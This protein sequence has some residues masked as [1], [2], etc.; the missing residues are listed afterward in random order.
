[1]NTPN[2][3]IEGVMPK[4]NVYLSDEL[5]AAVRD[6]GFPVS[7]VCQQALAEAVR[8]VG[9]AR[10]ASAAMRDP[11]FDPE[12]F[13]KLGAGVRERMTPRLRRA[14][15]LARPASESSGR[16]ESTDLLRGV[17]DE[18]ENL[19]VGLLPALDVDT[20]ELREATR[21]REVTEPGAP[22]APAQADPASLWTGLTLPARISIAAALEVSIDLGHNYLGCEHLLLGL[23]ADETSG[24]GQLLRRFGVEPANT[25]RAVATALAGFTQARQSSTTATTTQLDEIIRRLDALESRLGPAPA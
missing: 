12:R 8:A 19:A 13:P 22:D 4:I 24:A 2:R 18:G 25:R 9:V 7:P 6:A 5:A 3:V 17:L 10:K 21:L 16:V 11:D 15:E 1:M 20:D 14:L 23:V